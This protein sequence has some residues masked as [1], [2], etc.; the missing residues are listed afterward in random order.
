MKRVIYHTEYFDNNGQF[1]REEEQDAYFNTLPQDSSQL[2]IEPPIGCR[3]LQPKL[4]PS[5][6]SKEQWEYLKA[7]KPDSELKY[8]SLCEDA[9][10]GYSIYAIYEQWLGYEKNGEISSVY[11]VAVS[12]G[13]KEEVML[14]MHVFPM[15]YIAGEEHITRW[16]EALF[17]GTDISRTENYIKIIS[18]PDPAQDRQV[19]I[20]H[21]NWTISGKWETMEQVF[22]DIFV[23]HCHNSLFPFKITIN[24]EKEAGAYRESYEDYLE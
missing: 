13:D 12:F 14:E 2:E 22:K 3:L 8:A 20:Y 24:I 6:L 7:K 15:D 23:Y 9:N 10:G 17:E 16:D 5:K 4:V 18:S 11:P 21:N 19:I 1:L